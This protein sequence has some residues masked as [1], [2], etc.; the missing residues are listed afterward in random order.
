MAHI[1][2]QSAL[3]A[4]RSEWTIRCSVDRR[5]PPTDLVRKGKPR[6]RVGARPYGYLDVGRAVRTEPL[7]CRIVRVGVMLNE[8]R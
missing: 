8:E 3:K 7:A 5:R 2:A 6:I 4:V 1:T